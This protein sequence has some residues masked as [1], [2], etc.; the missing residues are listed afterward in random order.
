M[1]FKK[2]I[3][4]LFFTAGILPLILFLILSVDTLTTSAYGQ[5]KKGIEIMGSVNGQRM[6][7]PGLNYTRS[8]KG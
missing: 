5:V 4:L 8:I 2:S 3:M 6:H 1:I 7:D